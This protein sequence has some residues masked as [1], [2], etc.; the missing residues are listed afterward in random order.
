MRGLTSRRCVVS[1]DLHGT[2]SADGISAAPNPCED[3]ESELRKYTKFLVV[4][5]A[6]VALAVPAAAMA[7]APDGSVTFNPFSGIT[8]MQEAG[9]AKA[10]ALAAGD[11]LIAWG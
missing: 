3:L 11:N 5:G 2:A 1:T 4:G 8:T 10:G 7:D 9:A 6:L